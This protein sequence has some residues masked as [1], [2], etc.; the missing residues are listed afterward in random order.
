[1]RM[2]T[3][4]GRQLGMHRAILLDPTD[5]DAGHCHQRLLAFCVNGSAALSFAVC[6]ALAME[7]AT[8][9]RT[10]PP[11]WLEISDHRMEACVLAAIMIGASLM[12][13]R[14][15]RLTMP[16]NRTVGLIFEWGPRQ[17]LRVCELSGIAELMPMATSSGVQ[18]IYFSTSLP[19]GAVLPCVRAEQCLGWQLLKQDKGYLLVLDWHRE[20]TSCLVN[21]RLKDFVGGVDLADGYAGL[22]SA[23]PRLDLLL[24]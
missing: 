24:G 18:G 12:L 7:V 3:G 9:I 20:Q 14:L 4:H 16:M 2:K 22:T 17:E 21:F 23:A 6:A 5:R 1:M 10:A 19:L 15:S 11:D 13:G 8:S